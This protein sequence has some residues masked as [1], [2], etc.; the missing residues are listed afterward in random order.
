MKN[1]L[2]LF[3]AL[4]IYPLT[5]S[6]NDGIDTTL[7]DELPIKQ[8]E[9]TKVTHLFWNA[10][11]IQDSIKQNLPNHLRTSF[12][13][14]SGSK[15]CDIKSVTKT[16][17]SADTCDLNDDPKKMAKF[18]YSF[19]VSCNFG[20]YQVSVCSREENKLLNQVKVVNPEKLVSD[21]NPFDLDSTM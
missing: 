19:N 6:A 13:R 7:F 11:S 2:I 17:G 9:V 8:S 4:T 18:I 1:I 16:E 10:Q 3:T 5:L 12:T 15:G 20:S 14:S 21:D